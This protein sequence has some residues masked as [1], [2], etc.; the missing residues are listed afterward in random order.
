MK[1]TTI[2]LMNRFLTIS[3]IFILS[4]FL[5]NIAIAG[6]QLESGTFA[7]T[8]GQGNSTTNRVFSTLG[9]GQTIDVPA[10]NAT[11]GFYKLF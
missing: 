1:E 10:G 5:A 9:Q 8:G 4:L 2:M 11:N 6:Y 7:S 3:I